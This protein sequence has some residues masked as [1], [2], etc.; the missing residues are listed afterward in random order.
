MA[1]QWWF[2]DNPWGRASFHIYYHLVVFLCEL[3]SF[4]YFSIKWL[5]LTYMNSFVLYMY[6]RYFLFQLA[7]TL[8]MVSFII[9]KFSLNS[10]IDYF[11]P[12]AFLVPVLRN[13]PYLDGIMVFSYFFSNRVL[14][15]YLLYSDLSSTRNLL[16]PKMWGRDLLCFSLWVISHFNTIFFF[17]HE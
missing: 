6:Y 5:L 7:E 2:P 15:N 9:S 16:L 8:H 1:P 13:S 10:Q 4:S 12:C 14:K 17:A 11:M 3:P